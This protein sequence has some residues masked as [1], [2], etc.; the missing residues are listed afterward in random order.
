M[1]LVGRPPLNGRAVLG[2]GAPLRAAEIEPGIHDD[3]AATGT[4]PLWVVLEELDSLSAGG[5][6]DLEDVVGRPVLGVLAR[7]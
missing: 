2:R 6:G 4:A 3:R 1:G 5:T 7:T